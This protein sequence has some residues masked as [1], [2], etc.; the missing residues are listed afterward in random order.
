[1]YLTHL[2]ASITSLNL[3]SVD[4]AELD[5]ALADP[6]GSMMV[7]EWADFL[8]LG[9]VG[10]DVFDVLIIAGCNSICTAT[11]DT[12]KLNDLSWLSS[13]ANDNENYTNRLL[14]SQAFR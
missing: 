7:N 5:D 14:R 3:L 8:L 12:V 10:L 2:H 11:H 9:Q 1:M 4:A 6:R 13:L